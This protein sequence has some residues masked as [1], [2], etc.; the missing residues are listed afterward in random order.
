MFRSDRPPTVMTINLC[1]TAHKPLCAL[2]E[3]DNPDKMQQDNLSQVFELYR[4]V[5]TAKWSHIQYMY[6]Y[7]VYGLVCEGLGRNY[8]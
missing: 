6:I 8:Q 5:F 7:I 3:V 1:L 4:T 2:A